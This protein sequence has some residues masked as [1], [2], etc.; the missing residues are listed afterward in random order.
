MMPRLVFSLL[1]G[2]L[3]ASGRVE[4]GEGDPV[5]IT[6]RFFHLGDTKHPEWK[7][8]T[9]EEPVHR[10]RLEIEFEAKENQKNLVLEVQAGGVAMDWKVKLNEKDLGNLKK[11]DPLTAQYFQVEP[12]TLITGKNKLFVTTERPGDDIYVGKAALHDRPL[13]EIM[14][15]SRVKVEVRDK[16]T[17]QSLPSRLTI[18]RPEEKKEKEATKVIE[19]LVDVFLKSDSDVAVRKGIIY[20]KNGSAAFELAP[21]RYT[22]YATRGFEYG[23]AAA[24]I[25]LGRLEDRRIELE[26]RREVDTTG[27]LA[28]DSHIHTRT[29]SGHGDINLEE[30]VIAIA[31]EG[32]EVA[33]A[34]DHN[35]NTS[36]APAMEKVAVEDRFQ[37]VVGNEVT[38]PLGHF[39]AF[40]FDKEAK[41]PEHEYSDWVKLIQAMRASSGVRVI[42]LNHPR[43]PNTKKSPFEEL[44]YNPLSGEAHDGPQSLGIDAVEVLNAKTLADD[45]LLT[46]KDW[47]GLLN[48]G[49]RV[50]AVAAS[51]SHAVDEIVGQARTYVVSSTDDPR[52]VNIPEICDN[53]LAGRLL[54]SLGLLTEA[55]I[56]G[57]YRVGDLAT[58]LK[59]TLTV[60][61]KVQGPSWTRADQVALYL[62]GIEVKKEKL[63]P[64]GETVKYRATWQI[65]TPPHDAHLVVIASG[66]PITAPYWPLTGGDKKYVTGATNPIWIDGDGDGKFSSAFEYASRIVARHGFE[67][68]DAEL[69]KYDAAVAAQFASLARARVETEAQE[70]Y[71]RILAEA[72]Q[73]LARLLDAKQGEVKK[74]ISAYLAVA[75][76]LDIRTRRQT[77][78]EAARWK[79]EEEDIAKK[80][81][82]ERKRK[83]EAEKKAEESRR[84]PRGRRV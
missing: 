1:L 32:I 67:A 60:A 40:P 30:R 46:F 58:G 43:R 26:L 82:E 61:I 53:Y 16:D 62:N 15:L 76:K 64:S 66:P 80:R 44:R 34:T 4:A 6:N 45:R 63:E 17:G 75:P 54:T 72:D 55:E 83:A 25:E 52:K 38:T 68:S 23:L 47:F 51:D 35:H 74:A 20:T 2:A 81:A 71:D 18:V 42:I 69:S 57:K 73:K 65:P 84:P 77:E 48:R 59:E 3:L 39:N 13:R 37:S 78:E 24:R 31:G 5:R 19:E 12:F 36:Y 56:D 7:D 9:T 50:A 21:G 10:M 79:K 29:Y 33:I 70:A 22:I 27:Y 28:A 49:H 41:P 11:T 14:G 8:L